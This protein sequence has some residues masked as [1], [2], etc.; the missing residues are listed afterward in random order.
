MPAAEISSAPPR[1]R[2]PDDDLHVSC[3]A[4]VANLRPGVISSYAPDAYT[5]LARL[6]GEPT[7]Y[8][9]RSAGSLLAG[10]SW[11][12]GHWADL[13]LT[14]SQTSERNGFLGNPMP[15]ASANTAALGVS[16]RMHLGNGWETTASYSEGVTQFDL[17]SGLAPAFSAD[18]LRTRAYG[19][20]IA[21][22]GLFG[23]DALG[24]AVS[25]PA[26]S[27]DGEFITLPGA[28]GGPAFFT[29]N[30]LLSGASV[31]ETDIEVGYVTTFLDG[32]L[33]LQANAS[34]QMNFAGQTGTK[35]RVAAQPRQ[36][37]VLKRRTLRR[38]LS[39]LAFGFGL[40]VTLGLDAFWIEPDSLALVE[41][42]IALEGTAPAALKGL[43]IAVISDLHAGSPFIGE[44][45]VRHVVDKTN[46]AHPDLILLTGDYVNAG[47]NGG[48]PMP[49][50]RTAAAA[51]PSRRRSA[52]HAI[53]RQPRPLGGAAPRSAAAPQG[54]AG[55]KVLD[56][57]SVMLA[58]PRGPLW[59]V[60]IGDDYELVGAEPGPR[61]GRRAA[62]QRRPVLHPLA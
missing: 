16:A 20:A 46:A 3:R 41:H 31:P 57:A 11:S 30:H 55:I 52:S 17:K 18:A 44:A 5:A 14:A 12:I 34:Y 21:K 15:G 7:P 9:P 40:L 48:P 27:T 53:L 24:L 26:L 62:R 56:N 47:A 10:V 1:R 43:R 50:E 38:V 6:G 42:P 25:R 32:S 61:P 2:W 29:R 60:G 36:D 13:G 49:I 22:N 8:T 58:T 45:K 33:A 54:L 35:R 19:I 51:R 4:R 59:L 28:T 39:I 23:D 37:P